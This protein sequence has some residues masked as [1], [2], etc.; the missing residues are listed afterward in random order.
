MA[1][2]GR[3]VDESSGQGFPVDSTILRQMIGLLGIDAE[4]R[5]GESDRAQ[6]QQDRANGLQAVCGIF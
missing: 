5:A 2:R 3:V 6:N 1:D 4:I